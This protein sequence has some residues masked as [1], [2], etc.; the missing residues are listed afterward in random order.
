MSRF[1]VVCDVDSTLINEEVIDLL[2]DAAG[3]GDEVATLTKRAMRGEIDFAEALAQRVATLRGT[4]VKVLDDVLGAVTLTNGARKLVHAVHEAGGYII[5]VSGGFYEILNPIATRL[6]LDAWAANGL[7]AID[8]VFTGRTYG[9]LIDAAAKANF[10]TAYAKK[11]RIPLSS[12]IAVGDGANDLAMMNIA[13]LSVGFC[14]KPD[15]RQA[16]HVN[17][18]VRDLALVAP[19]FGRRAS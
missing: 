11:K 6:G 4:S 7:E 14:A 15:V 17:I 5:A 2:A 10:L 12:T 8:G 19:Y 3:S 13:G 16:A 1:I 9:P 18:D